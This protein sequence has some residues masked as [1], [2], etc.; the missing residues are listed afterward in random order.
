[1]ILKIL[2]HDFDG[3]IGNSDCINFIGSYTCQCTDPYKP[4]PTTGMPEACLNLQA[5]KTL[6]VFE[7]LIEEAEARIDALDE[8]WADALDFFNK[9][10]VETK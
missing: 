9:T 8:G 2:E 10:D 6:A 3:C 7:R 1:M 5:Y 4:F